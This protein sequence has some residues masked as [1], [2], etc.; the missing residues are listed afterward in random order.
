MSEERAVMVKGAGNALLFLVGFFGLAV[1]VGF[2]L[3][4]LQIHNIELIGYSIIMLL[5]L[6]GG[7]LWGRALARISGYANARSLMITNTLSFGPSIILVALG[8][9]LFERILVE[10]GQAN[11]PIHILFEIL[12]TAG[13]FV[14]TALNG[15]ANGIALRNARSAAR[16]AL[17]S[18]AAGALG[19][20]IPTLLLDL[21]GRRVGAPGAANT[22]T[23]ITNMLTGLVFAAATAGA[24]LALQMH[25]LV[26]MNPALSR[27]ASA[28]AD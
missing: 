1:A 21:A 7:S 5:C 11:M 25:R 8:L 12:F 10:Q 15:I 14:V 3:S 17:F 20:L 27:P 22:A 13:T 2:G 9:G 16:L 24:V 28:S 6:L 19:F 26:A 4:A 23:M 18:G